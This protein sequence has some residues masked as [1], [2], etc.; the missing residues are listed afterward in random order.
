MCL[1]PSVATGSGLSVLVVALLLQSRAQPLS[2]TAA[3]LERFAVPA[4]IHKKTTGYYKL[5]RITFMV[6]FTV[7]A[8]P[9]K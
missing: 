7:F 9:K 3:R 5:F 1:C 8:V 2:G 4:D 6:L